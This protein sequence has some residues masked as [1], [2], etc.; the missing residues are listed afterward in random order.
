MLTDNQTKLR[1][2][3]AGID[4][5]GG[6][7][8]R[9]LHCSFANGKPRSG[10]YFCCFLRGGQD[11]FVSRPLRI[12]FAGALYH[13]TSRGNRRKAIFRNDL[14]RDNKRKRKGNGK[15]GRCVPDFLVPFVRQV[16]SYFFPQRSERGQIRHIMKLLPI[17]FLLLRVHKWQKHT[18]DY[19][20]TAVIEVLDR[21]Q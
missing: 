1:V 15:G 11:G 12:E 21:L 19:C 14:D 18:N 10:L 7:L 8:L 5:L 17:H 4:W 3:L 6:T 9:S 16:L 20:V 2:R 13:V